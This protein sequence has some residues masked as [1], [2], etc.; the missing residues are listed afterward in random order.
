MERTLAKAIDPSPLK[1]H[2]CRCTA[3]HAMHAM[4]EVLCMIDDGIFKLW[5]R[6]TCIY[7]YAVIFH[8][9]M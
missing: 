4:N 9:K 6:F 8:V 2:I 1:D 5:E 3:L 7:P